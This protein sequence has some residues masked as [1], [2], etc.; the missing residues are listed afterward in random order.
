MSERRDQQKRERRRRQR[1]DELQ[2]RPQ[3]DAA[4]DPSD[5]VVGYFASCGTS[6]VC[7]R[8]ACVIAD[9]AATMQR[10]IDQRLGT[11]HAARY[12]IRKTTFGEVLR[13]MRLGAP[14]AFEP[15]AYQ[16]FRPLA[17]RAGVPLG[18]ERS[19]TPQP[20]GVHLVRVQWVRA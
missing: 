8:E 7:D 3:F 10:L 12:E 1:R 14:Y 6:A 17:E 19:E 4:H 15:A 2:R 18:P 11:G 5:V 16:R 13:G 20:G 9:S